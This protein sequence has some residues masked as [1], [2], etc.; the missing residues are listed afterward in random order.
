MQSVSFLAKSITL[1]CVADSG[2]HGKTAVQYAREKGHID[3]VQ[4]LEPKSTNYGSK[5]PPHTVQAPE[6]KIPKEPSVMDSVVPNS[7]EPLHTRV[8]SSHTNAHANT[9]SSHTNAHAS[10]STDQ[11]IDG[12]HAVSVVGNTISL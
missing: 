10:V 6:P 12:S 11:A 3:I 4:L 8:P 5:L 7:H 1:V 9:P 2:Q